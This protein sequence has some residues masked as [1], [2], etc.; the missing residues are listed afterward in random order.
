M[1]IKA[2]CSPFGTKPLQ[3]VHIFP[4][5]PQ[6]YSASSGKKRPILAGSPKE[7]VLSIGLN[8]AG[9]SSSPLGCPCARG[10]S[11]SDILFFLMLPCGGVRSGVDTASVKT[12]ADRASVTLPASMGALNRVGVV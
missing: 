1:K 10:K 6:G 7:V 5:A 2:S 11:L 3:V 12:M 4:I 8:G 9:D